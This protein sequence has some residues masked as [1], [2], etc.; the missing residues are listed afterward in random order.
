VAGHLHGQVGAFGHGERAQIAQPDHVD[1]GQDDR[2]HDHPA[3]HDQCLAPTAPHQHVAVPSPTQQRDQHEH[4]DHGED[5]GRDPEQQPPQSGDPVG[6]GA[7]RVEGGRAGPSAAGQL[8]G[9]TTT[10]HQDSP[11]QRARRP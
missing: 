5:H 10:N 6:A 7:M 8:D 2:R 11:T 1:G 9:K 3:D 4:G